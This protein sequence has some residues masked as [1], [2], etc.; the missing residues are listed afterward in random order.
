MGQFIPKRRKW[1]RITG[2]I[3][4]GLVVLLVVGGILAGPGTAPKQTSSPATTSAPPA[5]ASPVASS[6]IPSP[7]SN[8]A[9][10]G[11]TMTI[12]QDGQDAADITITS[13]H[14]TTPARHRPLR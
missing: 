6:P 4:A 7:A 3:L 13:V 2:G 8:V 12:T 9:Q 11:D 14:V 1:P 10:V 5:P